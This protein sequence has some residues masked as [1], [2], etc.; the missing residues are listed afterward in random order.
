MRI[1]IH[2]NILNDFIRLLSIIIFLLIISLVNSYSQEK[3]ITAV[4]VN[5]SIKIDGDLDE[6]EW[7]ECI[8]V[9]NFIQQEPLD[10]NPASEKTIVKIIR[11][12]ENIYFGITCL[13]SEPD[14][15]VA[16]EMRR[17]E[18]LYNDDNIEIFIDT[19]NDKKNCYYFR[20]NPMGARFDAF[21]TDEGRNRNFAWNTLWICSAKK[22][23]TGWTA[24]IAIPLHSIRFKV[25]A[26]SWGINFGRHIRR[27]DERTFWSYV[28]RALGT[29]GKYRVSL[30]GTLSGINELSKGNDIEIIPYISGSKTNEYES[31]NH[32]SE[33]DGGVDIRYRLTGNIRADFSYNTD[34]AQVEADQ[35]IVNVSRFNL[36]FPEKREF[37]LE[38]EGLYQFG[39]VSLSDRVYEGISSS[40]SSSQNSYRLFYSR[41]IGLSDSTKI[42]LIGG[43]KIA[44]KIG[45]SDIGLMSMQTKETNI[46]KDYNEPST[47]Y[48]TLRIKHDLL[49]NSNIG[50][51]FLNKQSS[52]D[53]YN[54]SIGIDAN[55]PL[56]TAFSMGGSLAKT[57]TPNINDKDYAGTF[58][59]DLRTDVFS[60][61]VKYLN[62]GDNFNPEMGFMRREKMKSTYTYAKLYKWIN[63]YGIRNL[64]LSSSFN[65]ITDNENTLETRRFYGSLTTLFSSGDYIT[66]GAYRYNEFLN[67]ED[68]IRDIIIPADNYEYDTKSIM[69][70]SNH[71]RLLSGGITYRFGE[72]YG[73]IKRSFSPHY[74]FK[75]NSHINIT[76]SYSYNYVVLQNGYF[77]SNVASSRITY[78]YN[79]DFYIKTYIQWNDLDKH[80][81]SNILLHYI[82]KSTNNFYLVYNE[83]RDPSVSNLGIKDRAIMLKFVY[84]LFI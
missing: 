59:M 46:T 29:N 14:K 36:F 62:L 61:Y 10:E 55:F 32:S 44:G 83:N 42:P 66:L 63:K 24:E 50:M 49:R 48:S 31:K 18:P 33:L 22:T 37:F 69:F 81:S 5:S 45:K 39:D 80:L 30:F 40:S 15:I 13:D 73:G 57:F 25:D 71:S 60:W 79:P 41:K 72:Y 43:T 17:D 3:I 56:T 27:K 20:T 76:T 82:H 21:I 67:E 12:N 58:F 77:C 54:R 75:P 26:D 68:D 35:E 47:N 16:N 52:S 65:Y 84:H 38:N 19:F 8:P 1:S 51:I 28:P 34:F 23:K 2:K 7:M 74:H 11:N 53:K 64:Q 70:S 6:E 9:E 78:M 4:K